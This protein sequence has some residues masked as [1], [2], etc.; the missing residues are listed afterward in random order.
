MKYIILYKEHLIYFNSI[1]EIK[2]NNYINNEINLKEILKIKIEDSF[3]IY[4][5]YN[6]N[7]INYRNCILEIEN[8][9]DFEKYIFVTEKIHA[10]GFWDYGDSY[11]NMFIFKNNELLYEYIMKKINELPYNINDQK[12][13][14]DIQNLKNMINKDNFYSYFIENNNDISL[15]ISDDIFIDFNLTNIKHYTESVNIDK[16]IKDQ[17]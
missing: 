13:I 3:R 14:E 4:Y 1:E 8:D 9:F 17:Y 10:H 2:I 11:N 6:G 12:K 7:K 16:K 15:E 5:L